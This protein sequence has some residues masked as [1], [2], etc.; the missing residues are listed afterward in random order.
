MEMFRDSINFCHTGYR[1]TPF[2]KRVYLGG[3]YNC[4]IGNV[5]ILKYKF[6]GVFVEVSKLHPRDEIEAG[7][8]V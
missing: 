6:L 7:T 4:Y 3:V 5:K 8:L 1:E 2:V